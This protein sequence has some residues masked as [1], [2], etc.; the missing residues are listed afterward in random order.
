MKRCL[1]VFAVVAAIVSAAPVLSAQEADGR[2]GAAG[3]VDPEY[4]ARLREGRRLASE[5]IGYPWVTAGN[6]VIGQVRDFVID[7]NTGFITHVIF[8]REAAGDDLLYPVPLDAILVDAGE[9]RFQMAIESEEVLENAPTIDILSESNA[10]GTLIWYRSLDTYW[11]NAG[12]V[13]PEVTAYWDAWAWRPYYRS[14]AGVRI[15][16]GSQKR[17]SVLPEYQI[18]NDRN[19]I[20]GTIE[21]LAINIRTGRVLST[22]FQG[23]GR[24]GNLRML[25]LSAY[26]LD[27]T[28]DVIVLDLK[29]ERF[30][31]APSFTRG[32]LPEPTSARWDEAVGQWSAESAPLTVQAGMQLVPDITMRASDILDYD[33]LDFSASSI[34]AIEDLVINRDGGIPYAL[35][36]LDNFLDFDETLTFVPLGAISIDHV[37]RLAFLNIASEWF[38]EGQYR[39]AVPV[40]EED[41]LPDVTQEGWDEPIRAYWSGLFALQGAAE[42]RTGAFEEVSG[43]LALRATELMDYEVRNRTGEDLG[44]IEDIMVNLE[45]A[46]VS[47]LVLAF[48]EGFL[49]LG[50]KLFALP[51]TA[52]VVK[53]EEDAIEFDVEESRLE[54]APGFERDAWPGED[55][56][57]LERQAR[58]FW[59]IQE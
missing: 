12:V 32:N 34:G 16:P 18:L 45:E 24:D 10:S 40:Y 59:E 14:L 55:D 57:L 48:D 26:L 28:S 6:E 53:P 22:L 21:D 47:Y 9:N 1:I 19:E 46:S 11:R 51:L 3:T 56:V 36:E 41:T 8:A 31:E 43:R 42:L 33:L 30:G 39:E 29:P 23:T 2:D 27:Y 52:A 13:T 49:G 15:L 54:N 17:Y 58:E 35:V 5:V 37:N 38:E 20:A 50:E 25:P 7:L 44:D 4:R